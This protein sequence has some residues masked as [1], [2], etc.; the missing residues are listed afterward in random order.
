[1]PAFRV[2]NRLAQGKAVALDAFVL[3]V[4]LVDPEDVFR[5]HDALPF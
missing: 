1:M 2:T 3:R 5:V 4:K